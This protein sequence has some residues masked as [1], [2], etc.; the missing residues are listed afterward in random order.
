MNFQD[1]IS[2]P[3]SPEDKKYIKEKA[4]QNRQTMSGFVRSRLFDRTELRSEDNLF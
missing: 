3:L 2:I 1:K 4:N